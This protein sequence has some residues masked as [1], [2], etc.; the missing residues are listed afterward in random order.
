MVEL[1]V[2][3]Q[4]FDETT[5]ASTGTLEL[6]RVKAELPGKFAQSSELNA[7][8]VTELKT[9]S[10]SKVVVA[11]K[12]M[13]PNTLKRLLTDEKYLKDLAMRLPREVSTFEDAAQLL[14]LAF[15]GESKIDKAD[16][17]RT[18]LDL[19]FFSDL[20]V[21]TVQQSPGVSPEDYV[22]LYSY[23]SRWKEERGFDKPMMPVLSALGSREEFE[24]CLDPIMKRV[25]QCLG[26]DMRGGF[27]YHALRAVEAVKKK[28]PEMW[29]HVFQVPPKVLFGRRMAACSQGM[30][31]PYFGVDSFTR[32]IVPPPPVPLTKDKINVFDRTA[33]SVMKR[34]EWSEV[35]GKK[36]ECDCPICEARNLDGFFQ[37]RVMDALARS[38]VHDHFAQREE[39]KISA[40]RIKQR[41]YR[42]LLQSKQGPKSILETLEKNP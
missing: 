13:P 15:R 2:K 5:S 41:S 16:D 22:S 25:P 6:G 1:K 8:K 28:R 39:L 20:D 42:K 40:T 18:I 36:L 11:A 27:H 24:K 32:W 30:I 9:L 3:D 19:Q 10:P 7:M 23:A 21:V 29:V 14:F 35:H 31:L 37:G 12:L 17:L 4:A 33:W 38:K 26:I 34:K